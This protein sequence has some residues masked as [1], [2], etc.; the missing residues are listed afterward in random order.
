[1]VLLCNKQNRPRP[2][3]QQLSPLKIYLGCW[4]TLSARFQRRR[5]KDASCFVVGFIHKQM[6][7]AVIKN[8]PE[9]KMTSWH[10]GGV[11]G[12]CGPGSGSEASPFP[13]AVLPAAPC[14]L[15][16]HTPSSPECSAPVL[17]PL[18][19]GAGSLVITGPSPNVPCSGLT[20][21]L[22]YRVPGTDCLCQDG[23]KV[24][25]WEQITPESW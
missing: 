3:P 16:P 6:R 21:A 18:A 22:V 8:V 11:L 24:L 1:M 23:K 9:Q 13:P 15:Q 25:R 2:P 7:R 17:A 5:R 20:V 4:V 19:T 12:D 10:L 14:S